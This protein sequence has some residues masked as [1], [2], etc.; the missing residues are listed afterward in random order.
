[1]SGS[2]QA[3]LCYYTGNYY[4][5]V[6]HWNDLRPI[7]GLVIQNWDFSEKKVC[8]SYGSSNQVNCFSHRDYAERSVD[9]RVV[10]SVNWMLYIR[11]CWSISKNIIHNY[12][13]SSKSFSRLRNFAKVKCYF[14]NFFATLKI[15]RIDRLLLAQAFEWVDV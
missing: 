3:R 4:C 2:V 15:V 11:K 9:P 8:R 13:H 14:F 5:P 12:F 6:C 1:M 10:H 7:P